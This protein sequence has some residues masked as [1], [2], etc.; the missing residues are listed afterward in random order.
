MSEVVVLAPADPGCDGLVEVY[1]DLGS[2][3]VECLRRPYCSFS[4]QDT[5]WRV[6]AAIL[7]EA[8][9]LHDQPRGVSSP[10]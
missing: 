8:Q 10:T 6:D 4:A 3:L 7:A 1:N 2:L 5:D 9:R